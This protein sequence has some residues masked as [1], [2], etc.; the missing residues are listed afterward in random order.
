MGRGAQGLAIAGVAV[1]CGFVAAVLAVVVLFLI[2]SHL[3]FSSCE[4]PQA[5]NSGG[6]LVTTGPQ[7][8]TPQRWRW[9]AWGAAG[10]GAAAG[11]IVTAL[12]VQHQTRSQ[13]RSVQPTGQLSDCVPH[14]R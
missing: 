7:V 11:G 12:L 2:H 4:V 9:V 13:Q 6:H 10:L 5:F 8:C 14:R 1:L 3:L